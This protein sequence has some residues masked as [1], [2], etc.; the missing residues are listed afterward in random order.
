MSF[1]LPSAGFAQEKKAE[2]S[3]VVTVWVSEL[4]TFNPEIWQE[5]GRFNTYNEASNRS[6]K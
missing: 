1:S 5:L 3:N 4:S 2:D 6:L